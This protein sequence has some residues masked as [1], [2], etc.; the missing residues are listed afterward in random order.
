ME[1]IHF[2]NFTQFSGNFAKL[3]LGVPS[4][5]E[6]WIRHQT[7]PRNVKTRSSFVL[8]LC[9]KGHENTDAKAA[10]THHLSWLFKSFGLLFLPPA[11]EVWGKVK[12]SQVRDG[13]CPWSH[14]PSRGVSVRGVSV[15]E[16][17]CP[18]GSLSRAVSVKGVASVVFHSLMNEWCFMK[19]VFMKRGVSVKGGP[20]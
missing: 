8:Q 4:C 19:R 5:S 1:L 18:G 12:F 6:S 7:I 9:C 2:L 3:N 15:L 16:G 10:P 17:L 14:G 13:L 20:L 11:N